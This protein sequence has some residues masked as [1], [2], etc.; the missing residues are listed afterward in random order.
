VVKPKRRKQADAAVAAIAPV[1]PSPPNDKV[2]AAPEQLAKSNET[3]VDRIIHSIKNYPLAALLIVCGILV[4]AIGHFSDAIGKTWDL[5]SRLKRPPEM[6]LAEVS[7]MAIPSRLVVTEISG[8]IVVRPVA[9]VRAKGPEWS[10]TEP[11]TYLVCRFSNRATHPITVGEVG[12]NVDEEKSDFYR[13]DDVNVPVL[14]PRLTSLAQW[15]VYIRGWTKT[16]QENQQD[17]R[18]RLEISTDT[19]ALATLRPGETKYAFVNLNEDV[20]KA[21]LVILDAFDNIVGRA[22]VTITR[23]AK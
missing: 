18:R 23:A 17:K 8:D 14:K 21:P 22:T 10:G 13:L 4:I 5:F 7:R 20:S 3:L 2:T 11:E 9:L 6:S 16:D 19:V 1:Q 15:Q 12:D